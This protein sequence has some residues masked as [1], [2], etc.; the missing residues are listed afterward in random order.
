MAFIRRADDNPHSCDQAPSRRSVSSGR[1]DPLLAC[2]RAACPP[3]SLADSYLV[4][5]TSARLWE[6]DD[7]ELLVTYDEGRLR[8]VA[9]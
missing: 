9:Q 7:A 4:A 3:G 5:L 6:L 8:F 1:R 2:T